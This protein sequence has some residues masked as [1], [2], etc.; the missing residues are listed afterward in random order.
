MIR[1][2]SS[3]RLRMS[4]TGLA[5]RN[6][7]S[8]IS[9]A[10]SMRAKYKSSS[11][12]LDGLDSVKTDHYSNKTESYLKELSASASMSDYRVKAAQSMITLSKTCGNFDTAM[13]KNLAD[14][15]VPENISFKFDY[16][17][18]SGEAKITEISDETYLDGV[19][20]ALKKTMKTVSLDTVANGSK[21][22]N[23]KM[24]EA[25]YPQVAE[26][27]EKCFGQDISDLSVDRRGNI[28]GMNRKLRDAVTS[29][30]TD[31][32]FDAR[33]RYGFP[34]KSL[35]SVIKRVVS[36]KS[37]GSSVSHMS[38]ER[39]SLKT[40]DG[41]ISLGSKCASPSMK[42]TKMVL[43][44]AAAGTPNSM[45]LWAENGDLF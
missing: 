17:V 26:A 5:S 1:N 29:E 33:S 32:S 7:S 22:L 27:L 43:R 11:T 36:D 37:A 8:R 20:S 2:L 38:F 24:A 34:A 42:D 18:S 3:I 30:M 44:A 14:E 40:A 16:D 45:D 21:I 31:R 25:Y 9:S 12:K 41:D 6:Y 39:G 10:M 13:K 19:Q 4:A 35:S 15:G 23:G 28:L